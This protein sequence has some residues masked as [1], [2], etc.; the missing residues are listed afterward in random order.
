MQIPIQ[1]AGK[2]A[3][4]AVTL[5]LYSSNST[6]QQY[7]CNAAE[8]C[9]LRLTSRLPAEACAV[10]ELEVQLSF[11]QRRRDFLILFA[12]QPVSSYGKESGSLAPHTTMADPGVQAPL[13][14]NTK[15]TYPR[16]KNYF[17]SKRFEEVNLV[18]RLY[19]EAVTADLTHWALPGG[20]GAW[21]K[22]T[23]ELIIKQPFT[24]AKV[25]TSFG[26]TWST[27]WFQVVLSIPDTW[28]GK[29]V[30]LR[31]DS[32]S[33]AT[34]WSPDG[35]V[36]QGFSS[37]LGD[38]FRTDY[39]VA[40][41]YDGT[42]PSVIY[43]VEMASSRILGTTNGDQIDPPPPDKTFSLRRAEVAVLDATVYKLTRDL[44]V[45]TQLVD[46]MS[47]ETVGY[48]A[49]FTG[50]QMVNYL[51]AGQDEKASDLANLYFSKGN[52]AR[53]HHL[54]AIGNCHIDTAW[55]WSY[56]ETK[57]KVARSFSSQLQL[58]NKYPEFIF[59]ASQAQQWAWCKELYPEL[60]QRIKA[61]VAE[62]RFLP[63]GGTWVEMD[64]NIPSGESFVR[65]FL[66]GQAFFE[67]E[68]GIRCKEFWL[69]DTFGYSPQIPGI[70]RHVGLGRFLTQKMSWNFVNKFP[71]HNFTWEG[72]DGSQVLAHFPPGDSYSM[73][74]TV[75]E[76][77]YTEKNLRDKGRVSVSAYLYGYGDGGGGPTDDMIERARRLTDVDGCPK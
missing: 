40:S 71:Y 27:H 19:P 70:M 60:F 9:D 64:G 14:K 37:S 31:W 5:A 18:D 65:Q 20:D 41:K 55:L 30:V 59:V 67:K 63:V 42:T 21:E 4:P 28:K 15:A 44:E 74:C 29:Q 1:R 36:L 16:I 13:H 23:F 7:C 22:W 51:I 39:I 25:G 62:G 38:Q 75:K 8:G 6:L 73:E 32:S 58:M 12:G 43:Y 76:A 54:A 26:P 49:L 24:P 45:L 2:V 72:I 77:R 52:G 57:R 50:N 3:T 48:T 56:S 10:V 11:L 66:H 68:L 47:S 46:E 34:L 33:E 17:T 61:R 53:A 35:H 69:P